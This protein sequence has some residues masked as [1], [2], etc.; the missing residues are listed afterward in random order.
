MM[1][2]ARRYRL[3]PRAALLLAVGAVLS[4][5]GTMFSS[6]PE[7]VGGLPAGAP[8]RPAETLPYQHVYQPRPVREAKPLTDSEQTKLGSELATLRDHQNMRAYPPPPPPPKPK[9]AAV[10]KK[11]KSAGKAAAPAKKEP[12]APLKLTN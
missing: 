2:N 5:C 7:K 4:A 9:A 11:D 6:L 12:G 10:Q 3:A 8:E 1:S